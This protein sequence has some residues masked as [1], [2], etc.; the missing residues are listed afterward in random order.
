MNN[1]EKKLYNLADHASI[2]CC[3]KQAQSIG[4]CIKKSCI[5]WG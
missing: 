5:L 4:A 2:Y 3:T 1:I